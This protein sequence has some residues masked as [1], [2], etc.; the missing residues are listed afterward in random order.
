MASPGRRPWPRWLSTARWACVVTVAAVSIAGCV[1]MPSNGPVGAISVSPQSTGVAGDVIQT[2]PS[3]PQPGESPSQIVG[4]FLA[5]SA[6]YP[7][8]AAIA[9]EYLVSSAVKAWKP[10]WS[11][12]V[13][14]TFGPAETNPT[15][16]DARQTQ[17]VASGTVQSTFNGTGQ[18]VSAGGR[19]VG[20]YGF[21]LTKV[22]GQWR[23]A[24]PPAKR[25]LTSSEF[26]AF[27]KPQ[28]LY[29]LN[30]GATEQPLVPDSVFVPQ[31][32]STTDLLNNLVNALLPEPGS[33]QSG[34]LL[35]D[36]GIP[37]SSLLKTA[38]QT[39]PAGTKLDSVAQAGTTAVVNLGGLTHPSTT[40]LEQISAQLA[41]TLTSSRPGPGGP[42]Q[43]VEL[44]VNGQPFVPPKTICGKSEARSQVQNQATYWCYNPY[45]PQSASFSFTSDGQVWS[46][47]A[48]EANVQR[49][50]VGPVV[51]VLDATGAASA[52]SCGAGSVLPGS[53]KTPAPRPY[54]GIGTPSE[55]AVS[56]DGQYV[57]VYSADAG[58]L[59][60]GPTSGTAKLTVVKD[61][62]S[63]VTALSWDR[64][65]DLWVAQDGDVFMVPVN[66]QPISVNTSSLPGNVTG[67]SVAP[68]GIRIA[69]IV[70]T[71]PSS[72]VDLAAIIHDENGQPPQGKL[73]P[74]S[75][76]VSLNESPVHLGP[77]VTKPDDL[78][79]YDADDLIVLAGG[80]TPKL[81]EVPV[82]GQDSSGPELAPSGTD[83]IT[84]NSDTNALVIG[85]APDQI[86]V[87]T[88]IEGPWQPLAVHGQNPAYPG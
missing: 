36:A 56:P 46:R 20:R 37:Q 1:G 87:S 64:N 12:T 81:F 78:T 88:N 27:Y 39:F 83:S 77:D 74:T 23:I 59:F 80:S 16:A 57:A 5:A 3:G 84:A 24:N 49:G 58:K 67:L 21:R 35:P 47:C 33:P 10:S 42:I 86:E 73:N 25:L 40:V 31:G 53:V 54:P 13:F 52:P 26:S 55:V 66:G 29:F 75:E 51:P 22:N 82:D 65:H 43:S 17:V 38:A 63:G 50:Q 11:V 69:L 19:P 8:N 7:F 76:A 9:R 6:N 85:V 18:F 34:S 60:T 71:G 28:N 41:W 62:G 44:E 32:T 14:S 72:K 70:Q 48:A 45:P 2:F 68:D 30:L 79:W 61:I 15:P 4:G